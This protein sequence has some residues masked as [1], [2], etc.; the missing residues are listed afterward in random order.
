MG[1]RVAILQSNY[2]PWKGY[3]DLMNSVDEFVLYDDMQYT[4]NDWRNRNKIKTDQGVQWLT[5][6]VRQTHL[7]QTIRETETASDLWRTKHWKTLA[8]AYGGSAHFDE[9]G[10]LLEP[11]YLRS[12]ET[13]LSAVN[14][15]FIEAINRYLGIATR[16]RW[17]SE[18]QLTG[19]R[20]ERLVD[21][22]RQTGAD[23]YLT[24]PSALDYLEPGL[25]EQAEI[26]IEV[27]SYAGYPQ[28]P[29][30]HP[31]FEH[32][33]SVVDLMFNMGRH[34]RDFMKSFAA[35]D[36]G[37]PFTLPLSGWLRMRDET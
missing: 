28:Y 31:P 7:A 3:F 24:G 27:A 9:V 21:L 25:F 6:P 2:I 8:H 20:S 11:L 34:A 15:A 32:G 36:C 14:H 13:R 1:K 30:L 10:A 29:Q 26:A 37:Q 19:G 22:C 35:S 16:L 18:F 23:T 4:K 12:A 33:V 17:S 5:I